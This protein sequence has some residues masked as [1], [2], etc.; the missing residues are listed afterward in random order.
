MIS[1]QWRGREGNP[2]KH[3]KSLGKLEE[4]TSNVAKMLANAI[5]LEAQ[6]TGIGWHCPLR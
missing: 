4:R 1:P 5:V 2:E 6:N 3:D